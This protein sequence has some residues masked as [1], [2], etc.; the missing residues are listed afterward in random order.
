MIDA[1]EIHMFHHTVGADEFGVL[2]PAIRM[3]NK[4]G[5]TLLDVEIGMTE[6]DV[7]IGETNLPE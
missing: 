3:G 1:I 7:D 6:F 2:G 4:T 5:Q